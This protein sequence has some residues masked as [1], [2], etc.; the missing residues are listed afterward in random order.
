MSNFVCYNIIWSKRIHF[1]HLNEC[2]S[3]LIKL[4]SL[5][6]NMNNDTE[7]KYFSY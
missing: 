4:G 1:M 3:I 5:L 2:K 6:A 7:K